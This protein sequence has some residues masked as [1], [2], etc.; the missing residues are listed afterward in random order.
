MDVHHF[1][2]LEKLREVS[3]GPE[4]YDY[5]QEWGTDS[6]KFAIHNF[7]DRSGREILAAEDMFLAHF[8]E[9]P[10]IQ[11]GERVPEGE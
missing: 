1:S 2:L 10:R 3:L 6:A 8:A 11:R 9:T 5:S 4:D 7:E